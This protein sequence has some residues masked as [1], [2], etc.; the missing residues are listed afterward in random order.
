VIENSGKGV[1]EEELQELSGDTTS[2]TWV[3]EYRATYLASGGV[4]G[5]P[6]AYGFIALFLSV[7]FRSGWSKTT[8]DTF[9]VTRV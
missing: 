2:G 8:A 4:Q 6:N 9:T 7:V 5:T 1:G 3:S